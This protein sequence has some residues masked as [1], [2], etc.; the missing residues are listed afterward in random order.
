[1]PR[2][3]RPKVLARLADGRRWRWSP[4]PAR[5]SSPIRAS[6]SSAR[7]WP[8]GFR[9]PVPGPSAVLAALVVAG[10]PTDRFF[11]EGFLP[12]R[13]PQPSR[14][15]GGPARH[16]RHAGL[17]RKPAARRRDAGRCARRSWVTAPGRGGPR[18]D[19]AVRDRPARHARP[20]SRPSTRPSR[21]PRARS[22]C[23]SAR[24]PPAVPSRP[25]DGD[26]DA[27]LRK[28]LERSRSRTPS[29]SCRRRRACPASASMRAPSR[30]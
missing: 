14:A 2:S 26:L 20:T 4:T 22:S 19:E 28:R 18:T 5:R 29:M 8:Q 3:M 16:P 27:L 7:P 1:M 25:D 21:P 15:P 24:R 9:H 10:L 13:P 11:F 17:L 23:W 6:S 30:W 12:P